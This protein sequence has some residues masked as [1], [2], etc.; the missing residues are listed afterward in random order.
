MKCTGCD[1]LIDEVQVLSIESHALIAHGVPNH[2]FYSYVQRARR[3][4][5]YIQ[6]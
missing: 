5:R 1:V 2:L 3:R 4:K 6:Q